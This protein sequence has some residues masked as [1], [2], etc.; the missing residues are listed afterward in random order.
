MA[1]QQMTK[2][3]LDQMVA[4][5]AEMVEDGWDEDDYEIENDGQPDEYTEWQDFMGGDD[6]D[7]GQ[8]DND[9]DCMFDY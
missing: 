8:Y 4:I 1:K 6:W 2:A 9:C 7:Q 5:H 3:E